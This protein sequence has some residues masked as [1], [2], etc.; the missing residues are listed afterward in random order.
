MK[1]SLGLQFKFTF[2]FIIVTVIILFVNNFLIYWNTSLEMEKQLGSSLESIAAATAAQI[3][4]AV[5]LHLLEKSP[6]SRTAKNIQAR[7]RELVE[8]TGVEHIYLFSDNLE[9]LVDSSG[10]FLVG[11]LIP[12]LR[13]E[14]DEIEK[15]FKGSRVSSILFR[16]NNGKLYK[17]GY[18]PV[19]FE[20]QILAAVGVDASATFLD[21]LQDVRRQIILL[22]ILCVLGAVAAALVFSRSLVMPL[23]RLVTAARR[24][25]RGNFL[26]PVPVS[27]TD[28]IG[29]LGGT[30][31]EMRENIL[32]RDQQIKMMIASIAHE[33]RNPLAGMELF[34]ELVQRNFSKEDENHQRVQKILD[35]SRKL[36][37]TLTNF[38]EYAKPD[39]PEKSPCTLKEIIE[40]VT[41]FVEK[42]LIQK[43]AAI[44]YIP[45]VRNGTVFCDERH[46]AQVMLNLF[47]NAVHAMSEGGAVTVTEEVNGSFLTFYV[48]DEGKGIPPKIKDRIFD[49]FVTSKE[50]GTG[51]GLAIVKKLI[52]ENG[53]EIELVKTGADG[54]TFKIS[55]PL[56]ETRQ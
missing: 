4:E 38:L 7:L 23:R 39:T 51:L 56:S 15:V 27:G 34:A 54:T 5:M 45:S 20:G 10:D 22:G 48:A 33:I 43:N 6:D 17:S 52:E 8:S 35:E 32:K 41:P 9:N 29:F 11:S 12:K 36:K 31:D 44:R 50:K 40:Q 13:F 46:F 53:G 42:D 49:P 2:V 1:R 47:Q 55:L 25:G 24:I 19:R 14:Q 26:E 37:T 30:M 28:E 18:A 21:V 3:D 16:G